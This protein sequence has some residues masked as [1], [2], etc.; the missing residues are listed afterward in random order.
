MRTFPVIIVA[1]VWALL[2][3]IS[4]S[5]EGQT[6][7]L[8]PAELPIDIVSDEYGTAKVVTVYREIRDTVAGYEHLTQKLHLQILSGPGAGQTFDTDNGMLKGQEKAKL[9]EGDVVTLQTLEQSDGTL[10][11]IIRDPY[12]L[13]AIGRLIILFALLCV[14]LGG[15]RGLTSILG[16]F[17]SVGVLFIF[18]VPALAAGY[19]PLMVSVVGSY[20]IA[21]TSLYL[22]HGFHKRTSVALLSTCITLALAAAAAIF[23]VHLT[24]LFGMGSEE[25]MYLV[26]GQFSGIDLRG[27]LIGGCIIGALGVLDDITTAQTAGIHELTKANPSMTFAELYNAGMSIGREHIASLINTLALAYVGASLP[28]MLLFQYDGNLPM[29][30]VLNGEFIAQEIVR[31][32]IGSTA[33]LLAVP[34]STWCAAYF[35]RNTT[36]R[37]LPPSSCGHIHIH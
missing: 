27:L 32:L 20:A 36:G 5:A 13:P 37:K 30:L 1:C 21:C 33:L 28:L 14:V 4:T 24:R 2:T 29:W 15:I 22:A 23:S 35:L 16:L 34:I 25:S 6:T 11:R 3:P 26:T 9:H 19:D 18:V 17:A 10:R 8:L 7:Q 31:T 12:R